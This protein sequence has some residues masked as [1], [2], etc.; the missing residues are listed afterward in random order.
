MK[1]TACEK[2]TRAKQE[3][4]KNYRG[5]QPR[6]SRC[7]PNRQRSHAEKTEEE[8]RKDSGGR[9]KRQRRKA[10]KT[11]EEGRTGRGGRRNMQ[12]RKAEQE[13][14]PG[15]AAEAAGTRRKQRREAKQARSN[16]R[17]PNKQRDAEEGRTSGKNAEET[18]VEQEKT[19]KKQ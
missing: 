8:D 11:A 12:W 14:D 10:E 2:E 15:Q 19:K 7:R 17:T 4:I 6:S 9:P 16:R 1:S 3:R 18:G 13:V 5:L